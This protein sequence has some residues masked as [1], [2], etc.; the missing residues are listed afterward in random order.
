MN[1]LA[2][3]GTSIFKGN[4]EGGIYRVIGRDLPV[5]SI[6]T[7]QTIHDANLNMEATIQKSNLVAY[8]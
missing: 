5:K 2:F 8:P 7:A 6:K 1:F 3:A 4:Y